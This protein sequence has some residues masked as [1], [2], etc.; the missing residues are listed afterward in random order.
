[1]IISTMYDRTSL[2]RRIALRHAGEIQAYATSEAWSLSNALPEGAA[3]GS[4][5]LA[6]PRRPLRPVTLGGIAICEVPRC[7]MKLVL[8]VDFSSTN[9]GEF[10][11]YD[12]S[13]DQ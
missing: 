2:R 4:S 12:R 6:L 1:M 7:S 13:T 5:L 8:E 11:K 3:L 10:F 9:R